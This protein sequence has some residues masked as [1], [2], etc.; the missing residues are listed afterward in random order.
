[1]SQNKLFKKNVKKENQ[2]SRHMFGARKK[3]QRGINIFKGS[4]YI[5]KI[6][7]IKKNF[8]KKKKVKKENQ[9]S[10]YMFGAYK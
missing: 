5:K 9:K 1:M 4:P 6:K 10:R 3:T 7:E 8:S 2:K